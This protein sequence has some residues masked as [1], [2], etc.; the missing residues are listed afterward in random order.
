MIYHVFWLEHE[1]CWLWIS[2]KT[3]YQDMRAACHYF[4]KHL[5]S[6]AQCDVRCAQAQAVLLAAWH[7]PRPQLSFHQDL[8]T[9]WWQVSTKM[10]TKYWKEK[11][12]DPSALLSILV[13]SVSLVLSPDCRHSAT[14]AD[15]ARVSGVIPTSQNRNTQSMYI[16]MFLFSW[17]R[18]I[19]KTSLNITVS[20]F[21][22]YIILIYS[23]VCEIVILS[24]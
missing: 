10:K 16:R 17:P 9:V 2:S 20:I 15:Q 7:L 12:T 23:K 8:R 11:Q 13:M 14:P 22:H 24:T 18:K 21:I 1:A 3:P 19:Q 4:Q 5:K 6:T